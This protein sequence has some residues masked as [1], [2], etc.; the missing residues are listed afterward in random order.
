MRT[1]QRAVAAVSDWLR[2]AWHAITRTAAT[3]WQYVA[4]WWAGIRNRHARLMDTDS[5]YPVALATGGAAAATLLLT[6]HAV[7]KAIGVLLTELLIAHG[8]HQR[9][10]F[11]RPANRRHD[12][13]A[14]V[15]PTSTRNLTRPGA[16]LWD[17]DDW[18]DDWEAEE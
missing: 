9:G 5:R 15:H 1:I 14:G 12:P 7:A 2:P 6:S 18:D 10:S 17:N 4:R 16:A 3:L 13:A 8:D 11:T